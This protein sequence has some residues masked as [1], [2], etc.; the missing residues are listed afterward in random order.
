M[1]GAP[2]FAAWICTIKPGERVAIVGPSGS[3]KTTLSMLV[4]AL[5]DPTEGEVLVDGHNVKDVTLH[6]LRRQIGVVFEKQLP[7]LRVGTRQYRLRPP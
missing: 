2:S 7:L 6:S 1:D 4:P 3:G 5:Y